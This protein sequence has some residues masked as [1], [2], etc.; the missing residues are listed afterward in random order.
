MLDTGF[1]HSWLVWLPLKLATRRATLESLS[2]ESGSHDP[3]R[4]GVLRRYVE[5]L[6]ILDEQHGVIDTVSREMLCRRVDAFAR[7]MGLP[8]LPNSWADMWRDW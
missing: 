6:N 2:L 8:K 4:L 5:W 3:D 7:G 1:L